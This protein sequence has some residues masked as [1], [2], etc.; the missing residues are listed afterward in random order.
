MAAYEPR[1]FA[2]QLNIATPEQVELQFSVAGLGSRFV[3]VLLDHLIQAGFYILVVL[4]FSFMLSGVTA[5]TLNLMNKWFLAGMIALNFCLIWGYFTLFEAFWHGQTPGKHLMKLRVIKDS[6]RQITLFE[7]M[8]RNLLRLVDY[9][10][11]LYLVGVIAI[12]CTRRHQRVGDL[13]AGTLVIHERPDEQPLLAGHTQSLFTPARPPIGQYGDPH[14]TGPGL[15]ADAIA[16]LGPED[17]LVIEAF[18]ARALDLSLETRAQVA[19]RI[20]AQ[21][22]AKMGT[23]PPPAPYANPE[24]LLEAVAYAMRGHGRFRR[25]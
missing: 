25:T 14:A 23:P 20:A 15:P 1:G 8:S 16:K 21:M 11:A 22:L 19:E 3:A 24:R 17:L 4:L 18:F 10:P 5:S 13:A 2:D 6:G 7:S 12:L 9:L